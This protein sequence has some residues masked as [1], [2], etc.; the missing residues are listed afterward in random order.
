M[1]TIAQETSSKNTPRNL[2]RFRLNDALWERLQIFRVKNR[3]S[4]Q[5]VATQ[6][7]ADYLEEQRKPENRARAS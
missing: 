4:V 5:A 1:S 3:T 7:I 6:A 2:I